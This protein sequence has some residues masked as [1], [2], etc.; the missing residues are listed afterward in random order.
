[1]K[2]FDDNTGF[3]LLVCCNADSKNK[4]IHK[5]AATTNVI[6]TVAGPTSGITLGVLAAPDGNIYFT[7]TSGKFY[8]HN[9]ATSTTVTVDVTGGAANSYLHGLAIHPLTKLL[10]FVREAAPPDSAV[11]SIDTSEGT[12]PTVATELAFYATDIA[13]SSSGIAFITAPTEGRLY[14]WSGSGTST[15]A[16]S[17][18]STPP[19]TGIAATS[20]ALNYSMG[21]AVDTAGNLLISEWNGCRVWLVEAQTKKL[22]LVASTG[23]CG[24]TLVASNPLQTQLELPS[25]VAF[26]PGERSAV[27]ADFKNS[28]V[29]KVMLECVGA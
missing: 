21:V 2:S 12:P 16:W 26:G 13:F 19:A 15:V 17:T 14:T 28:R 10:Y 11:Y 4:F 6:T 24:S 23:M 20:A 5:V 9:L 25:G 27:I 18:P 8:K 1:V 7:D 22:R 29:L 3:G